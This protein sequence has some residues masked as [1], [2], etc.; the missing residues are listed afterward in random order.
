MVVHAPELSESRPFFW[1]QVV[2]EGR[3]SFPTVT[4]RPEVAFCDCA[5]RATGTGGHEEYNSHHAVDVASFGE[6]NRTSLATRIH[7]A[8]DLLAA[9]ERPRL[10]IVR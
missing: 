8:R 3:T 10:Y 4:A 9:D 2:L 1:P 7:L 6:L 5:I